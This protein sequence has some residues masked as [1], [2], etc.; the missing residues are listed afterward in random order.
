MTDPI[1]AAEIIAERFYG[2]IRTVR[3]LC[4]RCRTHLHKWAGAGLYLA[5]CGTTYTIAT[6]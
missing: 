1:P 5:P 2:G 6:K 3:V 4:V